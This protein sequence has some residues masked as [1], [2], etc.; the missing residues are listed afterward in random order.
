MTTADLNR[1]AAELCRTHTKVR[2]ARLVARF[3]MAPLTG[4]TKQELAMELAREELGVNRRD[5]ESVRDDRAG[6]PS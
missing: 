4:W 6:L 1:R 2:L 3:E 5:M